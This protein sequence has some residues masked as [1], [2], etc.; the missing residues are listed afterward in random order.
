MDGVLGKRRVGSVRR[1]LLDRIDLRDR[2]AD[3]AGVREGLRQPPLQVSGR[4]GHGLAV[5][6]RQGGGEQGDEVIGCVRRSGACGSSRDA[7]RRSRIS[8]RALPYFPSSSGK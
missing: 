1:E 3:V 5:E 4:L 7:C 6:P 2:R 8:R